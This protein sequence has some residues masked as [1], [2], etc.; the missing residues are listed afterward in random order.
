MSITID[1]YKEEDYFSD[2]DDQNYDQNYEQSD[3]NEQNEERDN[4]YEEEDDE[5]DEM[6]AETRRIIW[7]A[8]MRRSANYD[9]AD[10]SKEHNEKKSKKKSSS[11]SN[12]NQKQK[13]NVSLSLEEFNKL[14]E[15][16]I[17]ENKPKKFVSKRVEEKKKINGVEEPVYKRQFN[18]R[19]PPYNFVNK[20]R[21]ANVP[22]DLNNKNDFPSLLNNKS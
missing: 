19:L 8:T 20:T 13:K 14:M 7:E 9:F 2:D 17:K 15:Q 10:I 5:D 6:D 18:P 4:T 12:K 16:K 11:N 21:E 3:Q 22:V 1:K